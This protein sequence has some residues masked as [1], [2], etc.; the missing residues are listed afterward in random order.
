M[1]FFKFP[2]ITLTTSYTLG[3]ILNN[4]CKINFN[5][6]LFL[7]LLFFLLFVFSFYRAKRKW[8]QDIYF[9]ITCYILVLFL[10]SITQY[11]HTDTNYKTHYS[12][13]PKEKT[14]V[15][16]GTISVVLKPNTNFY[17]YVLEVNKYNSKLC[18]GKILLY[19]RKS[20][21]NLNVGEKIALGKEIIPT[22]RATNPYQFD[23]SNYLK[24]QNIFHQLFCSESDIIK[25]GIQKNKDYYLQY[26]R[27]K[28]QSSF[29]YHH[30][31]KSTKGII[32]ALLFGQRNSIDEE[33]ITNYTASGV[34]HI[35]AISGLHIGILYFFFSFIFKPLEKIRNGKTI[36]LFVILGLL[37]FFA[38]IT[39]L[40]ASV[41][42]AVTLFTIISLG[43]YFNKQNNVYNS[44][45][46]SAIILLLF[47]PNFIFDIGFQ[48]SY[49]AVISIL[50]FQ[51]FYKKF[52]FTKN[53]ISIYFI[54]I[55]LVS[56]AAQI[57]VL[58]LTLYY[59]HQFPMLFLFA[60]IIVIP[61][62]SFVLIFGSITLLLNF[63]FKPFGYYLGKLVS[64]FVEIMNEYIAIIARF[65]SAIIKNISFTS[66]MTV[67]LYLVFVSFIY[68][69]YKLKWYAFRNAVI[70]LLI[71]QLAVI[72]TY[73]KK[74]NSD[75]LII[76][77]SKKTTLISRKTNNYVELYTNDSLKNKQIYLDYLRG[78]HCS[79]KRIKELKNILLFNENRI[80]IVDS[81]A[82]YDVGNR[83]DYVV[84]TQNTKLN[85]SRLIQHLKPKKIIA[86]NS[87]AFYLVEKWR[88]T[89]KNE[90]IPFHA[91]TEKGFYILK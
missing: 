25:L 72:L 22:L 36:K 57:G 80:L 12:A 90:K 73:L 85:L 7:I 28:L 50:L 82:I 78:S 26:V 49:A 23:Y 53:K 88:N 87:N 33:T 14:N 62:A 3:I 59:F 41:T 20:N 68:W 9:G 83:V 44:V 15:I 64:F 16:V 10:G 89:C 61:I 79:M 91:T 67:L 55:L 27:D 70:A 34:V 46:V 37:W 21:K 76:Y 43:G 17:K 77:N 8:F 86:D 6:L 11:L 29:E 1:K 18:F 58:P 84:L 45:A 51:P 5:L 13:I 60:N 30:F 2:I 35:L 65:D 75:E 71:F 4:Y 40:P 39:G 38:L 24:K 81:L 32:N 56:L 69:I 63:I 47:N 48:L 74:N 54:D 66:S 42:R 19:V 31:K 52:Y